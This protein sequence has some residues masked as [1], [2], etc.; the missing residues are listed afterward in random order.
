MFLNSCIRFCCN[1]CHFAAVD[2]LKP[3]Y[4]NTCA[5]L[6]GGGGIFE[7]GGGGGEILPLPPPCMN[8]CTPSG[9]YWVRDTNGHAICAYCDMTRSCGGVTG[10]WT[11]VA[12]LNMTESSQQCPSGLR[13]RTDSNIRTCGI[14]SSPGCSSVN[15]A[16]RSIQYS[17]VCGKIQ[18]YQ[19]GS[20]DAFGNTGRGPN[21][22]IEGNYVD[23]VSLT[24]G[25]PR[26]H[27]WTFAAG[28]DE[29]GAS[30]PQLNCPC[31]NTCWRQPTPTA[32][33]HSPIQEQLSPSQL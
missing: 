14:T 5:D 26:Q 22:T 17:K 15:F 2:A 18:S 4:Y 23:G 8:P 24:H 13:L 33:S 11:R 25:H 19:A 21:P 16:A 1:S 20:P 6:K 9:H 27:I 7:R 32:G 31:T 28:L 3:P 12:E 30:H 10:G 29:L